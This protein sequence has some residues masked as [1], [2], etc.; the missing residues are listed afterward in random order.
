MKEQQRK[1]LFV[2]LMC[3]ILSG[4]MLFG[5]ATLAIYAVLGML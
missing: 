5:A 4:L 3:W 1:G 2:R